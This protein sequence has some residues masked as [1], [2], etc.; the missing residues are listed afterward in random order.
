MDT[1]DVVIIGYGPVGQTLALALGRRG[2]RV[3][4]LE[5]HPELYGRAR[6]GHLDDEIM[7]VFQ[8][9]GVAEDLEP[10]MSPVHRYELVDADWQVLQQIDAGVARS[11][12]HNSY[13]F[14]QPDLEDVLHKAVE[15]LPG[16][17]VYQG[18]EVTAITQHADHVE[19][20][21]RDT[22]SGATERFQARY[23]VGAD[24]ARSFVRRA[25]GI[26]S[27]DLRYPPAT[28]LVIDIKHRDPGVSIPRMGELRQV[29]DPARPRHASRWNGSEHSRTEFMILPDERV[30]ELE[31]AD[32]CWKLLERYWGVTRESGELVRHALY[33][34]ET[35]LADRWRTGRVLLAGDAAHVMPPFLGQGMCSGLRDAANL[36]WRL[37]LILRNRA[38]DGLLDDYQSERRPHV[39]GIIEASAAIAEQCTITDPEAAR[40]RDAALAAAP[41]SHTFD[42]TLPAG[43]LAAGTP[44]AGELFVQ[45]RVHHGGVSTRLDDV[46][47]EG[48]RI[49]TRHPIPGGLI[50]ARARAIIDAL[51]VTL[52]H[53]TRGR[54][55]GALLDIDATYD[56]WFTATGNELVVE[57]PDHYVFG[58]GRI[59]DLPDLLAE[60]GSRSHLRGEPA[61][62]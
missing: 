21:A 19:V 24:G 17:E 26:T 47:G 46:L 31:S 55:P 12:W 6:A 14:Y 32:Q 1:Y 36:S 10:L 4:V 15:A 30:E 13:L 29:L 38:D 59:T 8:G 45:G 7:R 57:R 53:V 50:D 23:L 41:E 42:R 16:V 25:A 28:Y 56:Q 43:T 34:F 37:D 60:L 2:H 3:A 40:I 58:A 48:W 62:A 20:T 9:L 39:R 52:A 22:R 49:L 44:N 61:C 27:S 11:G 33:T 54:V 51:E 35:K 18:R 5:R